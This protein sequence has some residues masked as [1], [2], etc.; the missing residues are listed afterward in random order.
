MIKPPEELD[1]L[2]PFE[3][4][5]TEIS[6][7]FINLPADQIDNE[8][9]AKQRRICEL[10]DIDRSTLWTTSDDDP[11]VLLLTHIHQPPKISSPSERMVLLR[12]S[13]RKPDRF[14]V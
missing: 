8:I 4:L 6:T 1:D 2:L 10:L 3:R 13:C 12:L 9:V 14:S 7:P 5:L 11:G